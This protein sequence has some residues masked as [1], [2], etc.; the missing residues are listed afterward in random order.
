MHEEEEEKKV[1]TKRLLVEIL[2]SFG[3]PSREREGAHKTK[4]KTKEKRDSFN[5]T[6]RFFAGDFFF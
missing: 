4:K 6:T 5:Q 2:A 1:S 3:H